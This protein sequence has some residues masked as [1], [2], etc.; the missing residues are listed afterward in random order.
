[1]IYSCINR[2]ARTAGRIGTVM[3]AAILM[4][5]CA[6]STERIQVHVN[7]GGGLGVM[8]FEDRSGGSDPSL[9][10]QVAH[11]FASRLAL[12]MGNVIEPNQMEALFA[13][14]GREIPTELD[15]DAQQMIR[16]VT[17]CDIVVTGIVT[18]LVEGDRD[19]RPKAVVSIRLIDLE[20]GYTLYRRGKTLPGLEMKI[21]Y[22]DSGHLALDCAD[23]LA[24][25]M[26]HEV[27]C[28]EE[29]AAWR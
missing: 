23:F 29:A 15:S 9:G 11:Q 19:G 3:A 2:I 1:M 10:S 8:K 17:G 27:A 14:S 21:R 28:V 25:R 16:Q 22:R 7:S 13:E 6:P 5:G 26:T 18:R 24:D 12:G 20:S 4:A